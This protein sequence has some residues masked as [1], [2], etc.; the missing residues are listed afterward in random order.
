MTRVWISSRD[1]GEGLAKGSVGASKR[2]SERT[3]K[4]ACYFVGSRL[5]S[6]SAML[7][8]GP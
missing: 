1:V 4:K 2:T 5:F 3:M 6:V 8:G 7:V